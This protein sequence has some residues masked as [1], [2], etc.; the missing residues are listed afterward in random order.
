MSAA[1]PGYCLIYADM[2][3]QIT[4]CSIF[5]ARHFVLKGPSTCALAMS[6]RLRAVLRLRDLTKTLDGM[7]N[8]IFAQGSSTNVVLR[9]QHKC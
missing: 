4:W 1:F 3:K 2:V 6:L 5:D 7:Q 9:D 8:Y